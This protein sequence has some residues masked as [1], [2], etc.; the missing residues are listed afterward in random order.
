MASKITAAQVKELRD[1]TQVGMMD[2]KKALVAS[3]GDMDKAIDFLREKGI[4]KAKKKSGNVAANGLAKVVVSG[5]TAAIIEVNSETDFV[6]TNDT[7]NGLVDSIGDTIAKQEPAD[8]DAALA[9]KTADGDTINEAIVKTTQ[10]T[11]ENVQLRRFAVLKKTDSQVFGAYL[12][13]GGQIA[14]VVVL[15]G[16]DEET[17]KDVAMHVA[18]INPEFVSKEDIP[19]DRLAHEREVLK[20][21]AL[22]EGKPEK[23]VEKM[24]EGRLH[25][26]LAE[27]SLTDQA[28]VKDGDQTVGQFVASKGG[29]L[30]NFVRYE[31]GEGIEKP[32][33]DLAKEVQDQI[34]G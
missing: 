8:L 24:V 16:A 18:A 33:V 20:Q 28:F 23:I 1:K 29:K 13:Q 32:T 17:A 31:V 2:A 25:K 30:V 26:F 19:A 11:S 9:W 5:D 21:E 4:A 15:D 27:I 14:A 22:N 34:N 12:H 6:A 7:F 10:V 3:E